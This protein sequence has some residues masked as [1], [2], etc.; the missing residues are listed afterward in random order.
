MANHASTRIECSAEMADSDPANPGF[1]PP[2]AEG[3]VKVV[4]LPRFEPTKPIC[5]RVASHDRI[6][7]G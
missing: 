1:K 3:S 4:A 2:Y 5:V 6:A 7:A